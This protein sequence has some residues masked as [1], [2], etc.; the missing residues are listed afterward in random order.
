MANHSVPATQLTEGTFVTIR[1][2]LGYSRLTSLIEGAELASSDARKAQNG[3]NPVGRPHTTVTITQAEVQFKDPSNPTLEEAFVSERRYNST[4]DPSSGANYSIDNKSTQLPVIAAVNSEGRYEQIVPG[5]ELASGL[6]VTLVL[7]VYKP[8][9]F[10]NRGL[11]L[12]QV[13]INEAP[14]YFSAG[15]DT[16]ELAARG[17]VFAEPPKPLRAVQPQP[18]APAAQT[19]MTEDGLA[20]PAPATTGTAQPEPTR[21]EPAQP[22]QGE[23]APA[24]SPAM[25]GAQVRARQP[26]QSTVAVADRTGEREET[27]E[28]KLARL[29]AE[30]AAL[31]N[32]GPGSAVHETP[33]DPWNVGAPQGGITYQ[34]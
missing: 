2:K 18:S 15:V 5:S 14:R 28:E 34:G 1:G 11:S 32:N 7:R 17:I 29:T 33:D 13:L 20:F 25:A 21:P 10:A 26:V 31:K 4:K 27:V 8:R 22:T 3:M 24:A 30:N 16:E 9:N 23:T 6:D 12:D 19:Q